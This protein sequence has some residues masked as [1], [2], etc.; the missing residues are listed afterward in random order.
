MLSRG[1]LVLTDGN[2]EF[3]VRND[4]KRALWLL[5]REQVRID[6]S[7]PLDAFFFALEN[8]ATQRYGKETESI[9]IVKYLVDFGVTF[10]PDIIHKLLTRPRYFPYLLTPVQ[11]LR[12]IGCPWD[13][14][15]FLAAVTNML[16][17]NRDLLEYMHKEKCPVDN[18][19]LKAVIDLAVTHKND[20]PLVSFREWGYDLSHPE[21]VSFLLDRCSSVAHDKTK[22]KH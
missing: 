5:S 17:P 20:M 14:S 8:S 1:N 15:C 6:L 3:L 4:S 16:C 13:A 2:F 9:R 18:S 21:I 19:V 12:S 11:Y 7:R 10:A 22:K